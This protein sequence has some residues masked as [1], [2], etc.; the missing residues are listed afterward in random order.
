LFERGWLERFLALAPEGAV[1][2]VGCGTGE[3]ISA[4]LATARRRVTGVDFSEAMLA[5]ARARLP[6]QEWIAADMRGLALG[7][8]PIKGIHER[9]EV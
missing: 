9:R 3:P 1:L 6:S 2:D 5:I 4:Y 7:L 8:G